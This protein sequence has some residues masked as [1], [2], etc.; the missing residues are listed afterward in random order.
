MPQKLLRNSTVKVA[1][2]LQNA[3]SELANLR[4]G[5]VTAEILLMATLEQKDSIALKI[6]D[7]L[8]VDTDGIR[9]RVI[10]HV[11]DAARLLPPLHFGDGSGQIRVSKDVENL[12][13]AA[14]RERAGF[15]DGYISTGAFFLAFF[16]KGVP[17]AKRF[18]ESEGLEYK[19]CRDA[20]RTI[21]G[22]TKI[23]QKDAESRQTVLDQYTTD[24]T[25]MARKGVLDP[26]VGRESEI[27]RVIEILSRRKKNN[28]I[29]VGEPGVGKTVIVEG[30]AQQI[31]NA[32]VPEFLL[33]KRVLSL[34]IGSLIAGAK[35]QG[36]FEERLKSIKDEVIASAGEI[37]LFIDEL[38]TVVGA[39]RSGGGL[40]ASNMLKPALAKGLLRC[41]GA[42]TQREYKQYIESDKALERRFQLVR[43]L[44]PS[45]EDAIIIV[46]GVKRKYEAHHQIE[47]TDAAIRSAV[48]LSSRYIQDR[49]LPDKA[50]DL[51]D[52]AGAAKRIKVIYTPP[53]LRLLES[54]RQDLEADKLKA[55]N[56]Q[57]FEQMAKLQMDLAS[58][59]VE[60][61]EGRKKAA[62][63]LPENERQVTDQDI[64]AI[65][66]NSTGIP[67]QKMIAEEAEKLSHLE[68]FLEARVVGQKQAVHSVANAIRRNRSGLRRPDAP[69]A[70]FLFLGP[71]GVGKTELAKAL[72]SQVLDDE[73]KII[74]ID[75]SEYMERHSVSKLIG[76]PPGYVGFGQGG[77]LTEKIKHSPYSVVLFDEFEKAHPDVFNLLLQVLDEG[78][79]T[80]AEGQ[81]VS[82]RNCIIIGTSNI[83]SDILTTRKRPVGLGAQSEEWD[84][85]SEHKQVMGEVAKFLRPEFINRLDEV[86]IF[87]RLEK[88]ELR[89]IL[90]IQV[91]GLEQR[92]AT[93]GKT[94][95]FSDD[96]KTF[97]LDSIDTLNFGARPVR[98]KIETTIE[99]EVAILLISQEN[100]SNKRIVVEMQNGA[101]HIVMKP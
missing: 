58:L 11:L 7:E 93:L 3:I 52:E 101:V 47:Y 48:I 5:V 59:E 87:N 21:R 76:S 88:P 80:D 18:L 83:G 14:D 100:I 30:L 40:D 77:Q 63:H 1:E 92:L 15:E 19:K 54:K 94:L 61:A 56:D 60:L 38:H 12:F 73:S 98:R 9:R 26:V 90:D 46:N 62:V 65:V 27:R 49:F 71:T 82:F 78:W 96:V 35:M 79:L 57:D 55:F 85:G 22:S 31:V 74:R 16:D 41:I 81:R 10:N 72:A 64:A 33:G 67:V 50:I 4:K 45:V 84:K 51:I 70:S 34:E 39:G 86:I 25:A 42:T 69:I 23:I 37:I 97:I 53:E 32:D 68:S 43:V 44:E 17:E 75:M 28:P 66:S 89:L 95:E 2:I 20:L 29:L 99:N 13:Q 6:L 24:I 91:A 36:E 8:R